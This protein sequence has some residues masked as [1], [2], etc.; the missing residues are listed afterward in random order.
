MKYTKCKQRNGAVAG[1]KMENA[2][3]DE[4]Y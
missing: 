1:G 2:A 4:S 3:G